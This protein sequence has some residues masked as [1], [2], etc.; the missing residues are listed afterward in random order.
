MARSTGG[1]SLAALMPGAVVAALV[2]LLALGPV[3]ALFATGLGRGALGPA[4]WAAI[5]FTVLQ[6]TL[7]ATLSVA[8]A[9]PF[10]RALARRQFPG[11]AVIVGLLGAPFLLPVIVAILGL[12]AVWGRAG[13]P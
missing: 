3:A 6:S 9:I 12:L 7:S 2:L 13:A 5:R 8:L 4:D 11:R 1:L 10:A